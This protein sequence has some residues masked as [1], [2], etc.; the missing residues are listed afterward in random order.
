MPGLQETVSLGQRLSAF[1]AATLMGISSLTGGAAI[2][3][4]FDLLVEDKPTTSYYID[5]ASVLSISTKGGLNKK[6]KE[7]EVCLLAPFALHLVHALMHALHPCV[8]RHLR[9]SSCSQGTGCAH[10]MISI[11]SQLTVSSTQEDN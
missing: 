1:G 9:H 11:S 4:E 7:L 5:D 10:S 8:A 3:S 2:A 6:L